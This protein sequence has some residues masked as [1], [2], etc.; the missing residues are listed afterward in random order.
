MQTAKSEMK[1][2]TKRIAYLGLRDKGNAL[3]G[4]RLC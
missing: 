2:N 3:V 4:A 1:E